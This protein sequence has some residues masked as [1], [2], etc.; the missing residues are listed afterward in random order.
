LRR[1]I[2]REIDALKEQTPFG[3]DG[4]RILPE[5][6][7]ETFDELKIRAIEIAVFFQDGTS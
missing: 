2:L 1:K 4:I 7:V 5:I 3:R 6:F